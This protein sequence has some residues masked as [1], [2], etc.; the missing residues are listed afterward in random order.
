MKTNMII[1]TSIMILAACNDNVPASVRANGDWS[2]P[3]NEVFDGGPGKDGIPALTNPSMI[4]AAQATYLGDNA[5]VVGYKVGDDVRAYPHPILDWHEIIND[6]VGGQA[7]AIIYCPL[8][9]TG[10]TWDRTL[11][12]TVT[13][14][15]VSGLLYNTNVIPYDR[16]TDSN[17]SQMRLDCVNG[18]LLGQKATTFHSVETTWKTWREMFP[19]TKVVS[20]QTGFS[21]NY[22]SFPYGDYRTN[23]TRFLFP[24]S[25]QDNRLPNKER[26]LGIII[27]EAAKAYR[28]GSFEDGITV[29][30]DS[31]NGKQ[32]VA[33]GSKP[34]NFISVFERRVGNGPLLSFE[35]NSTDLSESLIR[36]N[37]G[38]TW[39]VF[40]EAT[41]GPRLGQKLNEVTSYI[42]YWFAW[43]AFY[44]NLEIF[45]PVE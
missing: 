18:Q 38:N 24:F 27:D 8:T 19:E 41:S 42:G 28:F 30:E 17:W 7:M 3:R 4:S 23:N 13:T 45:E 22:G 35:V 12:G 14:F 43:A 31:F 25:P 10:T 2:I 33:V 40:G 5:L 36:D 20:T 9:G 26:V 6:V 39:N 1:L 11:N 32:L 37:E 21:R 29:L 34:H 16:L 15:G 44:P